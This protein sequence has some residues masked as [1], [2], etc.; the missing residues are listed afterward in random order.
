V[1]A[2]AYLCMSMGDCLCVYVSEC[3]CVCVC[4]CVLA[5]VCLRVCACVCVCVY[6]Y[7]CVC[8]CVCVCAS[9]KDMLL[10]PDARAQMEYQIFHV[11]IYL[12]MGTCS[13]KPNYTYVY[14]YSICIYTCDPISDCS[15]MCV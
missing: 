14:I 7:V 1:R 13:K 10:S 4:V 8:V 15:D 6:L 12:F 2:C 11:C 3:V 5:C 9:Y